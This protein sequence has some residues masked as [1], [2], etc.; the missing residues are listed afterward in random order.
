MLTKTRR[1]GLAGG[2]TAVVAATSLMFASAAS[3]QVVPPPSVVPIG[4]ATNSTISEVTINGETTTV[5][6]VAP[7]STVAMHAKLTLG[8][9]VNPGWIYWAGYGWV[10]AASASG[11]S[12]GAIGV[13]SYDETNFNLTAPSTAGVYEVGAAL[14]PDYCPWASPVPGPTIAKIVV[15]SYESVCALAYEY[16]SDPSVAS[17]LCSKLAAAERADARGQMNAKGNVLKAFGNQVRAQ[18]G[19]ALTPEEA[20]M[21]LLLV[22]YL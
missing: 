7:N 14:G 16:S 11:C 17:G 1:L 20:E 12:P 2:F 13:G 5:A 15:T 19:K 4:G 10:G 21:L 6:V 22:S 18:T 8:P 3:A 9:G